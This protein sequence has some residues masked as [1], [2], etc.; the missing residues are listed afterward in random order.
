M[1]KLFALVV[2]AAAGLAVWLK[3]TYGEL[4]GWVYRPLFEE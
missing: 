2:L 3:V 4:T 1:K